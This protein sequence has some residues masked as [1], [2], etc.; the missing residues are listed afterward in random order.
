MIVHCGRIEAVAPQ[1]EASIE[2]VSAR[3]LA[4]LPILLRYSDKF[5]EKGAVGVFSKGQRAEAE[6]TNSALPAKYRIMTLASQTD[7]SGRIVVVK[8]RPES[9]VIDS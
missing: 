6:L 4:P 5:L 8:R 2:A 3:A 7:P 9:I 1:L